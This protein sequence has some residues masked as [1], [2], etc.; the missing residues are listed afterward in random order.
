MI[1]SI[2]L[3][4]IAILFTVLAVFAV[5]SVSLPV[6]VD[7]QQSISFSSSGLGGESLNNP[8]SLQFGPDDRLYVSQQNAYIYAYTIV[9]NG[10]NNYDVVATEEIDLIKFGVPNHNDDGAV[11]NTT[12]RQVTGI[13]ATGTA[14]NPVLYVSSSDWRIAVGNDSGLD[15]NSGV[16]SRLT[17]ERQLVTDSCTWEKVDIIRGLPRSEENHSTNG[18]ALDAANNVLYVM[19]GGH[20]NRGAPSN[21]FAGTPEYFLSAALLSVDLNIINGMDVYTDPRTGNAYVYDLPTLNDPFRADIDNTSPD[22]PYPVGHPLYNAT[23]DPG[24]PFGGNNGA[25][26][27]ITEPNGPLQVYAPGFRNAYDIVLTEGGKLY[28]SDNGPNGG[29]GGQAIF[30]ASDGTLLGTQTEAGGNPSGF[31]ATPDASGYYCTNELNESNS[32]T[33]GDA[34]HYISGSDYYG[35][36]VAPIRAFPAQSGIYIYTKSGSNWVIEDNNGDS[37][38]DIFQFG[39]LLN[40]TSGYFNT[41]LDISDYPNDPIQCWYG[42]KENSGEIQDQ[43]NILDNIGSST[44]GITEYTATNFDGAMQGNILTAS[45]NGSINRYDVDAYFDG[46]DNFTLP[47][48][49]NTGDFAGFLSGFGNQPL[50]VIAQGDDDIFP[51]TIWAATYGADNITIFEPDDFNDC[52]GLPGTIDEDDDGFT[53]DDELDNGTDP[54]SGGSKPTDNDNDLVSDLNDADDDNDGTPD[55]SDAFAIDANNGLATNLPVNH[56][57]WNNDP[58]TGFFGLGFTGLM[59]NGTNHW[60]EQYDFDNLSFGG[61]AGKATVDLV[62][63]GDTYQTNNTQQYAFQFGVN[64]DQTTPPFYIHSELEPPYFFVNGNQSN[65]ANFASYGIFMGTGDQDNYLKFVLRG[66]NGNNGLQVLL[67]DEAVASENNYNVSNILDAGDIQLYFF[68]DPANLTVQPKYALTG[69]ETPLENLVD[70]GPEVSVP[71]SW[72]DS[73]DDKGLAVGLISTSFGGAP[74]FGAT[75][76]FMNV[77]FIPSD[78]SAIVEVD[79]SGINGS[80]FGNSSF[81]I[82]NTSG[83]TDITNVTFDLDTALLPDVVFDPNGGAGDATAKDFTPNNGT[84]TTTGVTANNFTN[85]HDGGFYELSIDFNDF[86]PTETLEFAVDIDPT[87]IKGGSSPGPGESGSVSGLELTGATVTITFGD[88]TVFTGNLFR[89]DSDDSDAINTLSSALLGLPAPTIADSLVNAPATVSNPERTLAVTGAPNADVRILHVEAGMFVEDLTGPNAGVGFDVDAFEANSVIVINEYVVTTDPSGTATVDVTLTDSDPEA[90]FNYFIAAVDV[91]ADTTGPTSNVVV[92]EYDVTANTAPTL[93][94]PYDQESVEGQT[95]SLEVQAS[96]DDFD[97]LTFDAEGLPAGLSI[98]ENTGTISGTIAAGAATGGPNNDGV[99]TV[100]VSADDGIDTS[101]ENFTWTVSIQSVLYRVRANGA[102]IAATDDGPD[103]VSAGGANAQSGPGFAVNTGNL[104]THNITGRHTSLPDYVPTALFTNERWDPPATPEME[105]TFD[106][107]PGQYLVRLY[108]SN[109]FGGTSQPGQRVFDISIEGQLVENDFGPVAE[110]GH[111]MGGMKEYAVTVSDTTLNILFEHVVEN[112]NVNGIEIIALSP[113][114]ETHIVVD[115]ID[116]QTNVEGDVVD[117]L[118]VIVEGGDGNLSFEATGLPAGVQVEPTNGQIFGTIAAGA[119]ANSPYN[120]VITV[121]DSD[122]GSA[123]AKIVSFT[124]TV[125]AP[126]TPALVFNP[127]TLP[128]FNMQADQTDS[129]SFAIETNDETT[130]GTVTLVSSE[131]WLTVAQTNDSLTVDTTGLQPGQYTATLTASATDYDD[132]TLDIALNVLEPIQP[133]QVIYRVNTGGP[134]LA[135]IDDGPAWEE[136]QAALGSNANGSANPGTPSPY[137]NQTGVAGQDTT[138]GFNVTITET[139]GTPPDL[140]D[141]ERYSTLV[142]PDNMQWNFPV[143]NGEYI[144]NLYFAETWTGEANSPRVFDVEIEGAVLVDDLRVSVV[145]GGTNIVHLES[146]TVTVS[147][148]N[149]DID[150]IKGTQNPN[151]KA[152]EIVA[153][154]GEVTPSLVFNPATLPAFDLLVDETDSASFSVETSDGSSLPGDLAVTSSESWLTIAETNDGLTVDATGLAE[155]QYTAT[156]TASGTGFDSATLEVTLN[157]T[158][159]VTPDLIFNPATLPDYTLEIGQMVN[160][161]IAVETSD[162]SE[163]PGDLAVASDA[164]WATIMNDQGNYSVMVMTAN[165]AAGDYTAT[166]TASG[167]GYNEATLDIALTVIEPVEPGTVLYRVNVGGPQIAVEG[168]EPVWS[169]DQ[170]QFPNASNSPYLVANSTGN[171]L[172]N[173]N[174]G[175][176][177]SGDIDVTDPSIPADT[178]PAMFNTERYDA[179]SNPEMKWEFPISGIRTVEVRL[180]LAELFNGITAAGERVFDV[181]VEGTIP[182]VF[183]D[184]DQFAR[185]GAKGAFMLSY[186][187]EVTDNMLDIEFIHGVENPAL[188]GIE[189]IEVETTTEPTLTLVSPQD[190]DTLTGP[191]VTVAW[192]SEGGDDSDYEGVGI[193]D[194]LH[195]RWN[196]Q[197]GNFDQRTPV[198]ENIDNGSLDFTVGTETT[199]PVYGQNTLEIVMANPFHEEFES[200]RIVISLTIEEPVGTTAD[201]TGSVILQGRDDYSGEL[202]VQ[203]FKVGEATPTYIFMPTTDSNGQFALSNMEVGTYEIAVKHSQTLQVVETVTMVAGTNTFDFGTLLAGDVNDNNAISLEDFSILAAVFNTTTG[204]QTFDARADLNGDGVVGLEDFSLLAGNF[205]IT[206]EVPTGAGN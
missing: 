173:G 191:T 179:P 120:V 15:T 161:S 125:T 131:D 166:V 34:L 71:A 96:D 144:V 61:A 158:E 49:D 36:H 118:T 8:T 89:E 64:V 163:L 175:S 20:A 4:S 130:P 123:D 105:W 182:A 12:N 46:N 160:P 128:A 140:Y 143:G 206:G 109:G 51:G 124:W 201:L 33:H 93:V 174:S 39:D 18:M 1:R 183:D 141:T 107:A 178:P 45:Y 17:C 115:P 142:A 55:V 56:P 113:G 101:T 29:W 186:Q 5:F 21:N 98:D 68:V 114:N 164:A 99:Y 197:I 67:E 41:T 138:Y 90:G 121:D 86:N 154:D 47:G 184:I 185:N 204:D 103:W 78:S 53:N 112:P 73:N 27:A 76:D 192:A 32:N 57:F 77:D 205:N 97:T 38:P 135:S 127:A 198:Y 155:G 69:I 180:Y 66:N 24:D 116:D 151:I 150:F 94:Q 40:G 134:E 181:N 149:I 80:T 126:V 110:F 3:R 30:R 83:M 122:E 171:S 37:N 75:W 167:T 102:T 100:S 65:P 187:V 159:P 177:H 106:V 137:L 199:G 72:F 146:H 156:M 200:T 81:K 16:I 7:A 169:A 108:L 22:F 42:A 88:G 111:Q 202:T 176:A 35:G 82:T 136:D 58:G 74:E 25:N 19:Q 31:P 104:S 119:A 52:V 11:N 139:L 48:N 188:K 50:D 129:A 195:I 92:L 168:S 145:A 54:C 172:F 2:N 189:I 85:A 87:S 147:D 6:R 190:G 43:I 95:V 84:D 13:V 203:M 9:R 28:T 170:G 153:A 70:A 26:M 157:V 44:N 60:L 193:G 79:T 23:I 196:D 117:N 132:A 194:H 14:L 59:T 148:G 62:P 91:D 162:Q 133:G 165:L 10:D 63:D 152:I